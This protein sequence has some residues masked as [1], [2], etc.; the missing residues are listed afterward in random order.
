[1]FGNNYD[2][3]VGDNTDLTASQLKEKLADDPNIAGLMI[4][5]EAKVRSGTA[6]VDL[7]GLERVSG[8]LAPHITGGRLP[9]SPDEIA[10]GRVTARQLHLHIGD[11][12]PLENGA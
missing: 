7:A 3:Q 2:F 1:R 4:L 5:S 8:G 12:L 11:E 10:M 9:A 6:T